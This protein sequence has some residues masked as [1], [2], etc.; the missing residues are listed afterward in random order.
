MPDIVFFESDDCTGKSW[1]PRWNWS[2][3][4]DYAFPYRALPHPKSY[5]AAANVDATLF[6]RSQN[7]SLR[8]EEHKKTGKVACNLINASFDTFGTIIDKMEDLLLPTPVPEH[9]LQVTECTDEKY[10]LHFFSEKSFKGTETI[11]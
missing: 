4:G 1:A 11:F 3:W 5:R 10:C 8:L 9:D 2:G 6:S 7:D